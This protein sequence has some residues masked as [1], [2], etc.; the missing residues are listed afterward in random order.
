[1]V[2]VGWRKPSWL[3]WKVWE[4]VQFLSAIN[5]HFMSPTCLVVLVLLVTGASARETPSTLAAPPYSRR[6]KS[7]YGSV[8]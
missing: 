7:P 3:G 4:M 1:M 5:L 6:K 8:A 2:W